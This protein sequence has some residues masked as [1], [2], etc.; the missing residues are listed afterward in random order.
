[1][2]SWYIQ[3]YISI[4]CDI[5]VLVCRTPLLLLP[6]LIHTASW[7]IIV[8]YPW[9][10]A[11]MLDPSSTSLV[12]YAQLEDDCLRMDSSRSAPMTC[13]TTWYSSTPLSPTPTP[14]LTRL[15]SR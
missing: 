2:S 7:K 1:M 3:V 12:T 4:Y 15:A 14:P 6:L 9:K 10:T 11:V 5:L 8:M 13:C